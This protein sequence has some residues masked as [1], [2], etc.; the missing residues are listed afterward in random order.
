MPFLRDLLSITVSL[1]GLSDAS[2]ES[3]SQPSSFLQH[4]W[5]ARSPM[6]MRSCLVS[7]LLSAE[8]HVLF[9]SHVSSPCLYFMYI[10][11]QDGSQPILFLLSEG[12][13]GQPGLPDLAV[14]QDEIL[15]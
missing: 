9:L 11:S 6:C 2:P 3:N 10:F 8:P 15:Q 4:I 13:L 5:V 1:R 12:N 14:L 7:L